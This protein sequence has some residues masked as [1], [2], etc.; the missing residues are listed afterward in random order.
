MLVSKSGNKQ[1][2]GQNIDSA[3]LQRYML[4][5]SRMRADAGSLVVH[6]E[7][8]VACETVEEVSRIAGE[9]PLCSQHRCLQD[10]WDYKRPIVN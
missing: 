2:N 4:E 9:S 6:L 1:W 5:L 7:P 3:T 10:H 8:G